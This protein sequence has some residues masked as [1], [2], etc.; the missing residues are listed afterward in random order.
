MSRPFPV[1]LIRPT[2]LAT[3]PGTMTSTSPGMRSAGTARSLPP[4]WMTTFMA[5]PHPA[6]L[7]RPRPHAELHSGR[8][9]EHHCRALAAG[10]DDLLR[11]HRAAER[12][13][14]PGSR[15]AC[16]RPGADL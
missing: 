4:G 11:W 7:V 6:P 8:D 15:D 5:A 9:D 13:G 12:G 14:Q 16:A 3:P 1:E 10:W 2:R